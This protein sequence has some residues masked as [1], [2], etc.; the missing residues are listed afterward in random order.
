MV[1][2]CKKV[3]SLDLEFEIYGNFLFCSYGN[4]SDVNADHI[5]KQLN[6]SI[7]QKQMLESR[8]SALKH[9][10]KTKTKTEKS[11]LE[12][13]LLFLKEF[14]FIYSV[15][16]ISMFQFHSL[17]T[18]SF[19]VFSKLNSFISVLSTHVPSCSAVFAASLFSVISKGS[20][21]KSLT[22]LDNFVKSFDTHQ[23][24]NPTNLDLSSELLLL[25]VTTNA[26]LLK[27]S[28]NIC[29]RGGSDLMGLRLQIDLLTVLNCQDLVSFYSSFNTIVGSISKYLDEKFNLFPFASSQAHVIKLVSDQTKPSTKRR[30]STS[31]EP[32]KR[33]LKLMMTIPNF[34]S[35]WKRTSSGSG[36][37]T[38]FVHGLGKAIKE[39]DVREIFSSAGQIKSIRIPQTSKGAKGI[40]FVEFDSAVAYSQAL[41]F[42]GSLLPKTKKKFFVKPFETQKSA[43]N[44][45]YVSKLPSDI[46][47]A[48]LKKFL[49]DITEGENV[50]FKD[51]RIRSNKEGETV[52]YVNV[53]DSDTL[54]VVLQ[55]TRDKELKIGGQGIF[56][57]KA[58]TRLER[59]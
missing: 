33:L 24:G 44:I 47:A 40:A 43:S 27:I 1:N 57:D 53:R 54:D 51:I 58:R 34:L 20:Q 3:Y 17:V 8:I 32:S 52:A 4:T 50:W 10:K 41:L 16:I 38:V 11:Q 5:T 22:F 42:N 7:S 56:I 12:S 18:G 14:L 28:K 49:V 15:S 55:R 46:K 36:S 19:T 9:S 30:S 13:D 31:Q 35:L 25:S 23:P 45:L 6:H 29:V 39:P 59:D 37:T 48:D 2:L 26:N 21:E